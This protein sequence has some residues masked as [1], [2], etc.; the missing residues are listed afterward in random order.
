MLIWIYWEAILVSY[1]SIRKTTL[2]FESL[3]ELVEKKKDFRILVIPG[4]SMMDTFKFSKED[5][6]QKAWKN[7]IQP[8]LEDYKNFSRAG[9]QYLMQHSNVALYHHYQAIRSY[10][11]YG[12][13][14][15]IPIPRRY[16]F[17]PIAFGFQKDSPYLEIFNYYLK[18]MIEKGV[19]KQI[20]EK[21]EAP[22]QVCADL[23]GLPLS[24]ES[25]FIAFFT[26]I[27]GLVMGVVLMTFEL[28]AS[29]QAFRNQIKTG[30]IVQTIFW[31]KNK[32][33]SI[34]SYVRPVLE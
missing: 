29:K 17:A 8:H 13:C 34:K 5:I 18:R 26:L 11:E 27:V 16:H 31:L 25:C 3:E 6:W 20:S 30:K 10:P 2:P 1:L 21:Y 24:F 23:S 19:M 7:Q 32:Y 9:V 28:I 4:S 22:D 14:E 12:K 15:I 33:Y